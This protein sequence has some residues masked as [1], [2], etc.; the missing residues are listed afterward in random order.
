MKRYVERE[1]ETTKELTNYVGVVL[2]TGARGVIL[3]FG[4]DNAGNERYHIITNESVGHGNCYYGDTGSD[5]TTI[6]N[7]LLKNGLLD[8]CTVYCFDTYKELMQWFVEGI[9]G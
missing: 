5:G 6:R 3:E 2:S 8:D 1:E 9:K 4:Y 7:T